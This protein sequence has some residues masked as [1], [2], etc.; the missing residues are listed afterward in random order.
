[1][2]R[3]R[4]FDLVLLAAAFAMLALHGCMQ[5][6]QAQQPARE[7]LVSAYV[8]VDLAVTT[9]ERLSAAGKIDAAQRAEIKA[10]LK[11]TLATLD[12]G[13]ALVQA[14]DEQQAHQVVTAALQAALA[15]LEQLKTIEARAAP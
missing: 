14:K 15:V 5:Y 8:A 9:T 11:A 1:M 2:K 7:A 4:S 6:G 3:D 10:R 12:A 13:K